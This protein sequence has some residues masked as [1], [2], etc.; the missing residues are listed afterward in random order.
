VLSVTHYFASEVTSIVKVLDV[1]VGPVL[2][3]MLL[4][5]RLA[6]VAH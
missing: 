6:I 5:F 1:N 3:T 4:H 2:K